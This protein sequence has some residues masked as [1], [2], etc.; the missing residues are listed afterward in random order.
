LNDLEMQRTHTRNMIFTI[1]YLIAYLVSVW[2][3]SP[4]A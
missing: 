4:G 3:P 2:K 1:P